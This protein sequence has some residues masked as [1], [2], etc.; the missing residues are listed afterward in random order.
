[1]LHLDL[2]FLTPNRRFVV[3]LFDYTDRKPYSSPK[4][5]EYRYL[6]AIALM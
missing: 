1:M 2:E 4:D 5:A 3:K 6:M